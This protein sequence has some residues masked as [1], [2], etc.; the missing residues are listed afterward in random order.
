MLFRSIKFID[1]YR[2]TYPDVKQN[3][4]LTYLN[5]N[6]KPCRIDYIFYNN[7]DNFI[8][9]S[10]KTIG[11]KSVGKSV[12]KYKHVTTIACNDCDIKLDEWFSDHS[13]ILAEF[14][15]NP[16]K[17]LKNIKPYDHTKYICS[18]LSNNLNTSFVKN[19]Y[20][21]HSRECANTNC[22]DKT[23]RQE[24]EQPLYINEKSGSCKNIK[25]ARLLPNNLGREGC[26]E[27]CA[28]KGWPSFAY[29]KGGEYGGRCWCES[30]KKIGRA[31]V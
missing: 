25:Y 21:Y 31:H 12:N 2:S 6:D 26:S 1:A 10:I 4:G 7:R 27:E 5:K 18:K 23:T 17:Q 29:D 20:C 22:T 3:S 16:D 8:L 24:L 11:G 13:A 15:F 30:L 19:N 9:N 28:A 14:I